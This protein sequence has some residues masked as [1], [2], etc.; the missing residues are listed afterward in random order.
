MWQSPKYSDLNEQS[1]SKV[2]RF[3]YEKAFVDP[4]IQHFFFNKNHDDLV[5]MQTQ[6]AVALLGG[7]KNYTGRPLLSLHMPLK[8]KLAHFRRRQMLMRET[9]EE[10]GISPLSA[11]YWLQKEE[12]LQPH[13]IEGM[14][15]S[16]DP[17]DPLE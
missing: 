12:S 10:M 15:A 6:F 7:P 14:A 4:I 3:F 2:V 1:I 11:E 16:C 17:Q 8:I 13:I 9:L 5:R